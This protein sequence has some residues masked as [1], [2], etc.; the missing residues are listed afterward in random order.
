MNRREFMSRLEQLLQGLSEE[1]R[2]DALQYYED[3]FEDAGSKNEQDVIRNLGSP[4][5][6]AKSIWEGAQQEQWNQSGAEYHYSGEAA[7]NGFHDANSSEF[8]Y[9]SDNSG[10]YNYQDGYG[11]HSGN[12]QQNQ[13]VNYNNN[14]NYQSQKSKE[15]NWVIL[16]IL[17]VTSPITIPAV[18]SVLSAIFSLFLGVAGC[19]IGFPI[20]AIALFFGAAALFS[21]GLNGVA[22][23]CIGIAFGFLCVTFLLIPLLGWFCSTAVPSIY[24]WVKNGITNLVQKGGSNS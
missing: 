16:I 10:N 8:H 12:Y 7:D 21:T 5:D 15:R 2:K 6:V 11:N 13:N 24:R 19:I 9:S 17:I 18:F 3:Y 1:E 20:A 14:V 4:E 23:L 22:M